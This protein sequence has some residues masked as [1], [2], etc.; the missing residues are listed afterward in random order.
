MKCIAIP[1]ASLSEE[2]RIKFSFADA[3]L[4]TLLEVDENLVIRVYEPNYSF[5]S[6][7]QVNKLLGL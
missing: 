6:H 4:K 5:M 2:G 3:L 1:D 7:L